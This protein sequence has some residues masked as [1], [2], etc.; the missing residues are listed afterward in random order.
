MKM[1]DR[2]QKVLHA[3]ILDYIAT[4]DPVGSRTIARKYDLGVSPATVRNEMADLEEMGLIEQ[5]HTSAGRIPSQSGYRYYVDCLMKKE[6]VAQEA[7]EKI[8]GALMSCIKETETLMQIAGKLL[9]Q[10][11]NYTALVLAPFYGKNT[12]KYIQ[13]LPVDAGKAVLVIVLDN[14]H[15]EHRLVDVPD[16]MREEEFTALSALLNN[17]LRGLSVEQWRPSVLQSI[18]HQLDNQKK[19]LRHVME[20]IEESLSQDNEQKVYLGGTINILNQ[21]EFKQIEKVK[22]LFE[23]LEEQDV[24]KE[25]LIPERETG[26]SV[27]IGTENRHQGMKDCSLITATYHLNGKLIGT[28]GLL[29]PTRME[30][31][32][33]ISIVEFLTTALTEGPNKF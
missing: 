27:R 26:I 10:L 24:L 12:L 28:L 4:A 31:S 21:P 6:P 29:G 5:P 11:T 14:G 13:L 16:S 20:L 19:F 25:V 17:H 18:Y 1:D 15:V 7:K 8:R 23:L 2:K 33:A 3:I 30:Y 22:A 32:K 9:S